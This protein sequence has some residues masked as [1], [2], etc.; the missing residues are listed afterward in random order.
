MLFRSLSYDGYEYWCGRDHNTEDEEVKHAPRDADVIK[1]SLCGFC[2]APLKAPSV[3]LAGTAIYCS[4]KCM[5]DQIKELDPVLKAD[6]L[7]EAFV[8][9]M[10]SPTHNVFAYDID[11]C[12]GILMDR[13]GMTYEEAVEF[14][15][16]NVIGAYVGSGGPVFLDKMDIEEAIEEV[17]G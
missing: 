15:D 8:G 3:V 14:F 17:E 7:D 13:D 9:I 5:M 10:R 6:G 1:V 16:F 4:S 12:H 2:K 11:L